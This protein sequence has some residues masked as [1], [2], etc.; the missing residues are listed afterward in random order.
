VKYLKLF[1]TWDFRYPKPIELYE[2]ENKIK[3]FRGEKFTDVEWN[4]FLKVY[5]DNK[6][7]LKYH[8][9]GSSLGSK[10]ERGQYNQ[11]FFSIYKI[12]DDG[13]IDITIIKLEDDWYLIKVKGLY[14]EDGETVD[15]HFIADEF[16]EVEI[17]LK[18][19]TSLKI[20]Q[21]P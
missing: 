13:V 8:R 16:E 18:T 2:F 12:D 14:E 15:G 21:K 5:L 4:F 9:Y 6:E 1:E 3:N 20:N 11:F 19:E 10:S 17:F 7:Q